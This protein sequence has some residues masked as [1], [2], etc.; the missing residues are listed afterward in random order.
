MTGPSNTPGAHAS[1]GQSNPTT[2]DRSTTDV[3]KDQAADVAGNAADAGKHVASIAGDQAQ[4]V[5][6]EVTGQAKD[7]LAQARTELTDQAATQQQ[8]AATSLRALADE[9]DSMASNSQQQGPAADLTRQ[10]AERVHTVA[11]WLDHSEPGHLLDDVTGFARRKPGLF[12]ALAAGAGIAVGR[13]GRGA[14][15]GSTDTGSSTTRTSARPA[16]AAVPSAVPD[17]AIPS[18]APASAPDLPDSN[19]LGYAAPPANSPAAG[20]LP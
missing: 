4:E 12:L 14:A 7:L 6:Q 1:P 13:L 16:S 8:R 17:A 2:D 15:I 9:F 3:A 19:A 10:A 20:T 18:A 11:S 5:A